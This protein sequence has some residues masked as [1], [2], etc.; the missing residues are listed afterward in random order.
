MKNIKLR[1][2]PRP[3]TEYTFAEHMYILR[4]QPIVK[5]RRAWIA[6]NIPNH[7]HKICSTQAH[8]EG[9]LRDI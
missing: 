6:N 8:L 5:L 7:L 3:V 9:L 4:T 2:P 1:H